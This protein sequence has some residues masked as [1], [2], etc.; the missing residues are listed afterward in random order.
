[1]QLSEFERQRLRREA[2]WARVNAAIGAGVLATFVVAL[3]LFAYALV[4]R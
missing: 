4:S 2:Q 3:I 1:M